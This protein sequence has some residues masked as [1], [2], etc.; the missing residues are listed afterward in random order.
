MACEP[1]GPE[2]LVRVEEDA[3]GL[4]VRVAYMTACREGPARGGLEEEV[5][6]L[7]E[8]ARSEYT[9]ER[10]REDPIVR[11]YRSFYWRIDV[12]PTKTRP[13]SEALLRRA[14]RGRWP[15]IMPVVD[16]GNIASARSLVPI[17]LY[18]LERARPPLSIR[19]SRGGEMFEPIGGRP[20]TLRPGLPV[21]VDSGG[22]VMHLYPHRDSVHTMIR[23]ETRVLLALAAGVPGVPEGRLRWALELL[24]R[25]LGILD[26]RSSRIVVE[27]AG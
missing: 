19:L 4:G 25:L 5:Q 10:L 14:L 8:W 17:G 3:A 23:P 18:D 21:L 26:W 16:A 20:E 1:P 15:R 24:S 22:L 11:A 27:P 6:R 12:D 9:L 7:L 13:S 2:G